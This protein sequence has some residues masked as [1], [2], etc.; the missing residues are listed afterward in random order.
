MSINSVKIHAY[1][2]SLGVASRRK[3]EQMVSEG[4]VKVN[5]EVAHIGQRVTPGKDKVDVQGLELNDQELVYFLV[6][7]PIGIISTT[8]DEHGRKTVLDLLPA[9]ITTKYRLFPVGRL[10][11]DS[12]GLVLLTNDGELTYQL[13]HPSQ[14]HLK[15]YEVLLRGIPSTKALD[16]LKR[17]VKLK[18]GY[19]KPDNV[20]ILGHEGGNTWLEITLHE[21][22]YHQIRRM[23]SRIGYDVLELIR[24]KLGDYNLEMLD[25]KVY[26][27][28]EK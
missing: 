10:D 19:I 1:L 6:N 3:A 7:K 5:G 26:K 11:K 16:H 12:R 24:T 9:E 20:N 13:T 27:Q 22:R 18:E 15:V 28:V 2:A 23:M 21:G 14:H 4:K 17:G 25:G 8:D